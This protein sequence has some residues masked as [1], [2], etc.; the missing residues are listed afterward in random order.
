L[1]VDFVR[2]ETD[3]RPEGHGGWIINLKRTTVQRQGA[4]RSAESEST[5]KTVSIATESPFR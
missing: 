1:R 5:K 4:V 2:A 3:T